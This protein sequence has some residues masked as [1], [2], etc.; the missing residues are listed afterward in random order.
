MSAAAK[1]VPLA[2]LWALK[3]GQTETDSQDSWRQ[4]A[5]S[6]GAG[7]ALVAHSHCNSRVGAKRAHASLTVHTW[8]A[9][10]AAIAGVVGERLGWP[11]VSVVCG[12]Q[13]DRT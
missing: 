7:W 10:P 3:Q 6:R 5:G 11:L 12:R 8:S 1:G 9:I 13:S 2:F 4:Q